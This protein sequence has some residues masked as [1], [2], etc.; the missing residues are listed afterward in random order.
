MTNLYRDTRAKW[1]FLWLIRAEGEF[2]VRDDC[3]TE[4]VFAV[5]KEEIV[6]E[7][8]KCNFLERFCID[9]CL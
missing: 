4:E 1:T 2:F 9:F 8:C 7:V 3:L 6:C 5:V